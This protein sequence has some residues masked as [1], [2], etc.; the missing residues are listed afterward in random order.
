MKQEIKTILKKYWVNINSK[1]ENI[2]NKIIW[3]IKSR[4]EC[5]WEIGI[6]RKEFKKFSASEDKIRKIL[7]K[8]Q[9]IWF[10][11]KKWQRKSDHNNYLCNIYDLSDNFLFILWF[12]K[13]S[14]E[15]LNE[16]I[17]NFNKNAD[18]K[19]IFINF[20]ISFRK[21]KIDKKTSFS[22]K[23]NIITNWK[24]W[25]T[26]NLFNFLKNRFWFKNINFLLK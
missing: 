24:N 23:K 1:N 15:F 5:Y 19:A 6:S 2:I 21:N 25:K 11:L 3:S 7:E 12:L 18:I 22:L 20:W 4:Y 13:N 9:K 17:V 26:E 16:K 14:I 8:L 10:L